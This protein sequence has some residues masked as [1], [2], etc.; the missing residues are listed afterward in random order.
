MD[1]YYHFTKYEYLESIVANGLVTG[2]GDRSFSINDEREAVYL[3]KGKLSAALMFFAMKWFYE[4][5]KGEAGHELLASTIA[6]IEYYDRLLK[7]EQNR[8]R[9]ISF[10]R[11]DIEELKKNREAAI[12]VKEQ[13]ENMGKY[14]SF[15]E[16]WGKGVYLII[17]NIPDIKYNGSD[18]R[19]CWVERNINPEDIKIVL[20]KNKETNEII[21][22][23][24]I[25]INYFMA[26][27]TV[28]DLFAEY[29]RTIGMNDD[30]YTA[31]DTM[32]EFNKYYMD[33]EKE[34]NYLKNTYELIEMPIKEYINA[35][36][37][38]GSKKWKYTLNNIRV[39]ILQ[40]KKNAKNIYNY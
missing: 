38:K 1:E 2:I 27:T 23:K 31:H 35:R 15:E 11:R 36:G 26:T 19:N 7:K 10:L 6:S 22:E 39:L 20:L 34:F 25:I 30:K 9:R 21:D 12:R 14:P 24:S 29:K 16:Y 18:F 28:E 37:N 33:H 3:S 32:K 8:K 5:R 17:N 4:S 40:C 13:V